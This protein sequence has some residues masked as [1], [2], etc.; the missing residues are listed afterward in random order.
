MWLKYVTR[1]LAVQVAQAWN[2]GWGEA[3]RK[4]Y[5]LQVPSTLVFYDG[6]KTEYYV[7]SRQHH[8]YVAGLYKLLQNQ[9]FLRTFHSE[10]RANL[11][12]IL[13]DTKTRFKKD[14]KNLG[15]EELLKLYQNFV[16]P[17][18]AQFYVDMWTVF[19][20]GE[21]LAEVVKNQLDAYPLTSKQKTAYLLSLSSPLQPNDVMQERKAALRLSLE[22]N[23]LGPSAFRKAVARHTKE[24]CHIPV[25]DIDHEP[26]HEQHFLEEVKALK[27]PGLELEKIR[28]TFRNRQ[29]SFQTALKTLRPSKKFKLLLL[30]LKDNVALRDYRDKIRQQLNMELKKLYTEIG[31]RLKLSLYQTTLLTDEEIISHLK[32]CKAFDPKEALK[33]EKSFLLFQ[34]KA[35]SN[36]FSGKTAIGKARKELSWA[37]N[38]T[39]SIIKGI[40][41]SAGYT[42]GTVK[43]LYTNKDLNKV[44][45]GDVM[46]TTM[47]RQDFITAIRKAKA[48]VT[49][50]GSVTAHAAIIARELGIPC[51]VATKIATKVLKDGDLVEVDANQGIVKKLN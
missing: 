31:R 36:I 21:P 14:L 44:K 33:R 37:K 6:K 32:H 28:K 29:K 5:G 49:D 35:K 1:R 2:F 27:N 10:A 17:R 45:P 42:K 11:E 48:L 26:Y 16:L 38:K 13:K 9:K 15:N 8:L 12:K 23:K 40:I 43:I 25:Y 34:K 30:F 7:D 51:I 22:K 46:V 50:E 47:T 4:K 3:M 24:Y 39:G 19:N 18:Q 20:I 41:G